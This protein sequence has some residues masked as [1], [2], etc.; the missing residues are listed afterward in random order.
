MRTRISI[1]TADIT[2]LDVDAIVNAANARLIPARPCAGAN[3]QAGNANV[4][5]TSSNRTQIERIERIK[6]IIT[7]SA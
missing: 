6:R 7:K 2:T 4:C 5:V 3:H 1:L